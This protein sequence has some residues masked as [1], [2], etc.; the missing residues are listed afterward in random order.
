MFHCYFCKAY[1]HFY[2]LTS[3]RNL[4]RNLLYDAFANSSAIV[5]LL[6][7]IAVLN[8]EYI[9][10]SFISIKSF[11]SF[12]KEVFLQK[13]F[14]HCPFAPYFVEQIPK[15]HPMH[16]LRSSF[17]LNPKVLHILNTKP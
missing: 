4:I 2:P 3:E 1:S 13:C 6:L 15:Y 16:A 11:I 9:V 5:L 7:F 10:T 12:E 14:P 17:Y 8:F